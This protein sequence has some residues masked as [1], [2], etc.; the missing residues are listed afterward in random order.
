MNPATVTA[1]DYSLQQTLPPAEASQ[2]RSLLV[3]HL[4]E[5]AYGLFIDTVVQIIPMLK[6]TPIPRLEQV[7]EGVANIRGKV[8]P[9]L[10]ARRCLGLPLI[11]PRLYTP[12][13]LINTKE[14]MMG[15]IVDEVADV[16]HVPANQVTLPEAIMP[17]GCENEAML[18]GVVYQDEK[19]IMV[20][21]PRFLLYPSQFRVV[22]NA[23]Q[24][25]SQLDEV[26][27]VPDQPEETVE[28]VTEPAAVPGNG[29]HPENG[30][31]KPRRKSR[32]LETALAGKIA[33]LA[34]DMPPSDGQAADS[35]DGAPV[36]TDPQPPS[37]G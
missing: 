17:G 32:K 8:V 10:C 27:E 12:I 15:L 13:I 3:F 36:S 22:N 7:I 20:L 35:S 18:S 28:P 4:G 33:N 5:R 1:T 31:S 24:T 21:D 6:L 25:I 19:A 11:A 37:D 34:V 23:I 30:R 14:R 29:H 26:Q 9:V 16:V 2:V